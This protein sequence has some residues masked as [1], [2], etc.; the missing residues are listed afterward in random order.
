MM[1]LSLMDDQR[2]RT[3]EGRTEVRGLWCQGRQGS[4]GF[5]VVMVVMAVKAVKEG[6]GDDR[7]VARQTCCELENQADTD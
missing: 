2:Q 6:G 3:E 5:M 4:H 1:R 7:C